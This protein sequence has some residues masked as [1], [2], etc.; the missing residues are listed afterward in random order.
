LT[1]IYAVVVW[2][3][4]PDN[5]LRVGILIYMYIFLSDTKEKFTNNVIPVKNEL[6]DALRGNRGLCSVLRGDASKKDQIKDLFTN[7]RIHFPH[8]YICAVFQ[9]RSEYISHRNKIDYCGS[10]LG[11]DTMLITDVFGKDRE[12]IP[13]V[14]DI[15][16]HMKY[17]SKLKSAKRAYNYKDIISYIKDEVPANGLVVLVGIKN[18]ESIARDLKQ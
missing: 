8:R 2:V 16:A 14:K 11:A 1:F 6:A 3:L 9:P 17:Y 7:L 12:K 13:R 18:I 4:N 5:K 15:I 10:F